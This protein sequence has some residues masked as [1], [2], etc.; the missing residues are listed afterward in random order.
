MGN[1]ST[2]IEHA[3]SWFSLHAAQR[4]QMLNYWLVAM[5]FLTAAYVSALDAG[6][7]GLAATIGAAGGVA[8]LCFHA[9]ERRTRELVGVAEIAL[10]DLEHQLATSTSL[11]SLRLVEASDLR[12]SKFSRYGTV[13]RL[14][15]LGAAIAFGAA[16]LAA[17]V[18]Y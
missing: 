15:Q 13:I 6:A 14:V 3:W 2:A 17:L 7:S 8:S 11:E 5:A 9:L 1:S 12:M 10:R 16:A 18:S 4:M